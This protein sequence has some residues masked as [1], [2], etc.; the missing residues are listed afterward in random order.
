MKKGM[1]N[2][3]ENN[4]DFGKKKLSRKD[5]LKRIAKIGLGAAG[6]ITALSVFVDCPEPYARYSRTVYYYYTT[7]YY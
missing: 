7:Y 5:A 2:S 6:M 4:N 3:K 1:D